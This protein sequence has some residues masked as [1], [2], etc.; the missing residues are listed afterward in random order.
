MIV[1]STFIWAN[2]LLPNSPYYMIYLWWETERE[3]WS[4]S[5]L[6]VKGLLGINVLQLSGISQ[7]L[8]RESHPW[9]NLSVLC[10]ISFNWFLSIV[11]D[12]TSEEVFLKKWSNL[13]SKAP[14]FLEM[15]NDMRRR[16]Q[17]L[18]VNS[19]SS[20]SSLSEEAQ[21]KYGREL[22]LNTCSSTQ[23]FNFWCSTKKNHYRDIP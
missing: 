9:M 7:R 19:S 6:G 5:P 23:N 18:H 3:N 17:A 22:S 11:N 12:K 13:K 16:L 15:L 4:W 8:P 20:S 21:Y 1:Q 10:M 14:I 2:Y